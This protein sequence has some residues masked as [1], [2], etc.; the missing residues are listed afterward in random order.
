MSSI[1]RL[2]CNCRAECPHKAEMEILPFHDC[3]L[4]AIQ[5][6]TGVQEILLSAESVKTL[7]QFLREW[8]EEQKEV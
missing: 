8:L 1:I 4:L 5:S 3:V 6:E 7:E 2:S